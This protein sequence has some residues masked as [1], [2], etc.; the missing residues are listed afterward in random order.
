MTQRK[1]LVPK[2]ILLITDIIA[3]VVSFIVARYLRFHGDIVILNQWTTLAFL[4]LLLL[5]VEYF[6]DLFNHY[7]YAQIG[8]IFFKIVNV[9]VISF[10][11]YVVVGFLTKFFFLINSRGFIFLFFIVFP[12]VLA[13]LRVVI[14]PL[15]LH[16]YFSHKDRR[17]TCNYI[18]P[19]EK[20]LPL[21][22]FFENNTI[23]GIKLVASDNNCDI[24]N[25]DEVFLYSERE[26][27]GDLYQEI[28]KSAFQGKRIHVASKLLNDLPLNWEWLK[29]GNIP[30]ISFRQNGD[31]KWQSVV[32]RIVDIVLSIL[33]LIVVSPL[34]LIVA[35]AIKL[36]SK[37]PI[38]YKQK[39]C[40]QNGN[41]FTLYKFRS[42]Y[43]NNNT[44]KEREREF[45]DYIEKKVAKGKVINMAEITAVGKIIRRASIDEFPQFVNVLKGDMTLIGPRPP[46]PYEVKYYKD[47]HKDRLK[48]KPGISGL[49]QVYGRGSMPCDSSIF[50]DL[51]YT[52]NR[53]LSLD[54]K[55]M[56][57]TIPAVILG[58]GAY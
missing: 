29:L 20:F 27:F 2:I 41:E 56:F 8:R 14:V 32:R 9:W 55:L 18:G 57:Q 34:L 1:L 54:L 30:I 43:Y 28:Q 47:W 5:I 58:K 44:P 19:I 46:I 3:V 12:L 31:K 23:I 45:K 38:I 15:L 35:I 7:Y 21:N 10:V 52:L 49:W 42:M 22:E 26:D 37:G 51:L 36:D 16:G 40:G 48:V 4:V 17:I 6:Y 33:F 53:S 13:F 24:K 50:L 39:R 11:V 25:Y